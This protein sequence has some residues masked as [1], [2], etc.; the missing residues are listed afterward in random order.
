MILKEYVVLMCSFNI[1]EEYTIILELYEK[2][3]Q[4]RNIKDC[5]NKTKSNG[6]AKKID[7]LFFG[8]FEYQIVNQ[9]ICYLGLLQSSIQSSNTFA[10]M[11]KNLIWVIYH[12]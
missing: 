5:Q 2:I 3:L 1:Y 8:V 7:L 11:R 10:G 6:R 12:L 4:G 9:I